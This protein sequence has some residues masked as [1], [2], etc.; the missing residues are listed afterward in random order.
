MV[1]MSSISKAERLKQIFNPAF[2]GGDFYTQLDSTTLPSGSTQYIQN[3]P[4]SVQ[5]A[6]MT[7]T[8]PA[9][10]DRGIFTVYSSSP[11]VSETGQLELAKVGSAVPCLWT[12]DAG[13]NRYRLCFTQDNAA[14]QFILMEDATFILQEDGTKIQLE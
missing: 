3:N 7:I 5:T 12:W 4:S 14:A 9:T 13:G 8:G 10:F 1:M 6:T 2:G 11:T